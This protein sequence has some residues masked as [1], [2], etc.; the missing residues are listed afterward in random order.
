VFQRPHPQLL[1][2][3]DA[4]DTAAGLYCCECCSSYLQALF[5][6]CSPLLVRQPAGGT[7]AHQG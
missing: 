4:V 6:C 2:H 5:H 1:P 3:V 7:V